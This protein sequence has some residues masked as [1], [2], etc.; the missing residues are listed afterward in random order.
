MAGFGGT[1]TVS[2]RLAELLARQ[3]H[4]VW[5]VSGDGPL[6]PQLAARGISRC[7]LD[8]YGRGLIGY[9]WSAVRLAAWL[10][11]SRVEVLHCQMA[12][13][14]FAC[15]VAALF[16]RGKTR[17][18]WHSRGLR[19][20]TYPTVCRLFSRLGI[21]AIANCD[22]EKRK[23][24]RHGFPASRVSCCYNP[25]PAHSITSRERASGDFVLGSLSRL[26]PERNVAEAVRILREL[27]DT[28]CNAR[29][30][31]GGDGPELSA[32]Q[33]LCVRFGV[34]AHVEFVGRV[35]ALPSFFGQIDVL[36][37][38]L[39]LSGD[40]GAGVGNNIIE[41]ALF[42]VPVVAYRC[43]GIGEIV[44]DNE[45]GFCVPLGARTKFVEHLRSLAE[46]SE[47]RVKLGG[48]LYKRVVDLCSDMKIYEA[49]LLA[50]MPEQARRPDPAS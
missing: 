48:G 45:T 19:A 38:P 9:L 26:A 23:L 28:G 6:V 30:V 33:G 16:G 3:G 22:H 32:L 17:V 43:A 14:V 21:R 47:L 34:A 1:E 15:W 27:R 44:I 31:I 36:V 18:V 11:R 10:R 20:Q 42:K 4:S 2:A 39:Q 46:N 25:L 50:Y 5:L 12:R 40:D 29:L 41:S 8:F 49:L 7:N 35:T 24:I 37:N 13:P